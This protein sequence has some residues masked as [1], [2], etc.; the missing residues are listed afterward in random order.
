MLSPPDSSCQL[1]WQAQTPHLHLSESLLYAG[2]SCSVKLWGQ[3]QKPRL[4]AYTWSE[5]SFT[6]FWERQ[7]MGDKTNGCQGSGSWGQAEQRGLRGAG[8]TKPHWPCGTEPPEHACRIR[9]SRYSGC[10]MEGPFHDGE[11]TVLPS[12]I[13]RPHPAMLLVLGGPVGD[14][15]DQTRVEHMQGKFPPCCTI[16]LP[17]LPFS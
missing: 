1:L 16:R 8:R 17:A 12:N 14:A 5:P 7:N 13:F 6:A 15:G 11:G 9:D 2:T 3:M 4:R 10:M